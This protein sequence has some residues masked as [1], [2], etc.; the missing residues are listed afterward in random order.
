MI[1]VQL[2]LLVA[3]HSFISDI[4]IPTR[5]QTVFQRLVPPVP[6]LDLSPL[7]NGKIGSMDRARLPYALPALLP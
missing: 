5:R 3:I 1:I 2:S 7:H 6:P 4:N